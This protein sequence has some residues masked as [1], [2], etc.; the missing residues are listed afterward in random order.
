[1]NVSSVYLLYVPNVDYLR[2]REDMGKLKRDTEAQQVADQQRKEQPDL[3]K[4][5]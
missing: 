4:I 2:I 3:Q 1:M 5:Q